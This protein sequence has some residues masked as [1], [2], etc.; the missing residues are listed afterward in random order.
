MARI[1]AARKPGLFARFSYWYC[2]RSFGKVAEP[3][4]VAAHHPSISWGSGMFELALARSRR[5]DAKLKALAGIK[6]ATL[7]GCPF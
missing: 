3:L 5:V 4:T 2:R 6:A 1:E 7:V